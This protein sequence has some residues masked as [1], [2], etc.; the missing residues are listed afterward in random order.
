MCY[1]Y[2]VLYIEYKH[3]LRIFIQQFVYLFT[4]YFLSTNYVQITLLD[5][6]HNKYLSLQK[7]YPCPPAP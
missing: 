5:A 4:K 6:M 7:N 3:D 1:V 2:K